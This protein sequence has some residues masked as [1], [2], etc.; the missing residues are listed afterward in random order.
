MFA[1]LDVHYN[2]ATHSGT[3]AAVVFEQW[4]DAVPVAEYTVSCRRVAAYV[5]GEFFKRELPCLLAVLEKVRQP[6]SAIVV[7]GYVTLGSRAGLGLC[8]WEALGQRVPV[9]GVAKSR[10][11]G[12]DAVEVRRGRS[13]TPLYV[14]AAGIDPTQAAANV[15]RMAGAFRAPTIL[16]RADRLARGGA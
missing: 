3:A 1:A 5:P 14:T 4:N 6:L 9:I 16:K 2:E 15:T 10:F 12:A 11:R 8:L 13:K 7:D